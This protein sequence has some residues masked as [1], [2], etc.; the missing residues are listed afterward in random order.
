MEISKEA[1]AAVENIAT[2]ATSYL[3]AEFI[4]RACDDFAARKMNHQATI[5]LHGDEIPM[6]LTISK[7]QCGSEN[8]VEITMYDDNSNT[9]FA[10]MQMT[11]NDFAIC[12]MGLARVKGVGAVRDLEHVGKKHEVDKLTYSILPHSNIENKIRTART[13]GESELKRLGMDKEGWVIDDNFN[14]RNSFNSNQENGTY[15]VNAIIRRWI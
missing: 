13:E 1:M 5:P 8:I 10:T 4:Q 2:N 3:T 9:D 15:T 6:K 11:P 12:L 7:I 14:S